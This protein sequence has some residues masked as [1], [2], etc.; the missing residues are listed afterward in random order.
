MNLSTCL[1][2]ILFKLIAP[3]KA[4]NLLNAGMLDIS[5]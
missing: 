4:V 1:E 3:M 2:E 5:I